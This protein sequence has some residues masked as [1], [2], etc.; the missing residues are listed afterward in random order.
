MLPLSKTIAQYK[1]GSFDKQTFIQTMYNEHHAVLFD[2][3]SYLAQT[4][5]KI[6]IKKHCQKIKLHMLMLLISYVVKY[7]IVGKEIDY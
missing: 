6:K 2:Y 4:P 5:K 3:A 7:K 1:Q